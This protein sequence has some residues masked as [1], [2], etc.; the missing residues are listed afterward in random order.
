L[1]KSARGAPR[2]FAAPFLLFMEH[3][4][5]EHHI[6]LGIGPHE[7][8]VVLT[9]V[10]AHGKTFFPAVFS[11]TRLQNLGPVDSGALFGDI[12]L[13]LLR[14][15]H[16]NTCPGLPHPPA[17]PIAECLRIPDRDAPPDPARATLL[18]AHVAIGI[19]N[20]GNAVEFETRNSAR[21]QVTEVLRFDELA[22]D[23]RNAA[24]LL[25]ALVMLLLGTMHPALNKAL[26][27]K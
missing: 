24:A 11:F 6:A 4:M 9:P 7:D 2:G 8:C 13:R 12:M 18:P 14:I 27:Q 10:D 15:H 21:A 5:R 25:G 23:Y 20:A 1:L 26:E 17:Q 22:G 19:D 3:P 16:G